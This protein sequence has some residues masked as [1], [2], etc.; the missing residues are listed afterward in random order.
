VRVL[1]GYTDGSGSVRDPWALPFS[2]ADGH[3]TTTQTIFAGGREATWDATV[4]GKGEVD[5]QHYT[6]FQ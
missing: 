1:I 5:A 6:E 3:V 2:S 4:T